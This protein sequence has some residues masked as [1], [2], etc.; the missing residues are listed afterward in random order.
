D[1]GVLAELE[2]E[3]LRVGPMDAADLGRLVAMRVGV[4]SSRW[5]VRLHAESGGNPFIALEMAR[6]AR[7]SEDPMRTS[8]P[9]SR[10]AISTRLRSLA[11]GHIAGLDDDG[12]EVS[13]VASA[14]PRPT[15]ESIVAAVGDAE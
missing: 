9:V 4:L 11:R 3:T 12:L 2:P 7:V 6:A 8:A 5:L 1:L 15:M 13:I 10:L 14:I